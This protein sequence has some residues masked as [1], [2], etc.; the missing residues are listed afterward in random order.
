M[1]APGKRL[2]GSTPQF[3]DTVSEREGS[4]VA[5]CACWKA[6]EGGGPRVGAPAET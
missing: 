6:V 3:Y 2:K 5:A 4:T 1:G